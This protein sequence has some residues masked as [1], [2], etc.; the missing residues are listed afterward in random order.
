MDQELIELRESFS[1]LDLIKMIKGP[2]AIHP[3]KS[4]ENIN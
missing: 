1:V 4:R 3:K 2:S